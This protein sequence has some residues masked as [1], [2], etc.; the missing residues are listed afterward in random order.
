MQTHSGAPLSYSFNVDDYLSSDA[1]VK[2]ETPEI[3]GCNCDNPIFK[4]FVMT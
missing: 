1:I 4:L 2:V 3:I